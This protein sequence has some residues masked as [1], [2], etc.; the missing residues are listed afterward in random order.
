MSEFVK[1][2]TYNFQWTFWPYPNPNS[3]PMSNLNR[4]PTWLRIRKFFKSDLK[5]ICSEMIT[6]QFRNNNSYVGF[7]LKNGGTQARQHVARRRAFRGRTAG[8]HRSG[9]WIFQILWP[10]SNV[11]MEIIIKEIEKV[12]WADKKT[13]KKYYKINKTY[14]IF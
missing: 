1:I 7:G 2:I 3:D 6:G 4:N 12:I 5:I 8:V 11:L 13:N 9:V 14:L 10:A